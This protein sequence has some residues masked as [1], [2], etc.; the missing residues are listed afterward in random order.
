MRFLCHT[1]ECKGKAP[2]GQTLFSEVGCLECPKQQQDV[3]FLLDFGKTMEN[4]ITAIKAFMNGKSKL[5]VETLMNPYEHFDPL[6][7]WHP[8]AHRRLRGLDITSCYSVC[9]QAWST[10]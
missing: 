6:P 4:K 5:K 9:A 3:V 1:K 2:D 8:A 7:S 10:A